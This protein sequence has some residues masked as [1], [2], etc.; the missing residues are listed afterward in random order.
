MSGVPIAT[1]Q[2][3]DDAEGALDW[4][5]IEFAEGDGVFM[6]EVEGDDRDLLDA[7]A[8]DPDAPP[9]VRGLAR[10]LLARWDADGTD[11][12]AFSVAWYERAD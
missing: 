3:L 2:T 6:G 10:A 11:A 12:L 8:S 4:I 5:G 1:F 7:V 9:P